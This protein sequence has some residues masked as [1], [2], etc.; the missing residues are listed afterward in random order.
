MSNWGPRPPHGNPY[1]QQ[2]Q[3]QQAYLTPQQQQYLAQQQRYQ[4]AQQ[5]QRPPHQIDPRY[6][7]PQWAAPAPHRPGYQQAQQKKKSG[8]GCLIAI[9]V[10]VVGIPAD[11]LLC[12]CGTNAVTAAR[13]RSLQIVTPEGVCF[14]L[15]L[16]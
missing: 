9:L 1:G 16:A 6:V 7:G 15:P 12:S 14:G 5:A 13:N 8:N 3:Q 2:P 10:V 11:L 4:Y